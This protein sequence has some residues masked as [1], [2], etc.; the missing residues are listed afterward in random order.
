MLVFL[1]QFELTQRECIVF[2]VLTPKNLKDEM[3]VIN[4]GIGEIK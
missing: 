1:L 3:N 2:I 4:L